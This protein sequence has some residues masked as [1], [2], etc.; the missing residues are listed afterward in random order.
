MKFEGL[1]LALRWLALAVFAS[2]SPTGIASA[3]TFTTLKSFGTLTNMTGTLPQSQLV[4]GPDGTLYG[5]ASQGPGIL[6]GTVF[7]LEPNGSNFT[8]LKWFTNSLDGAA[9]LGRLILLGN[10][11]Y[12]TT[13]ATVGSYAGAIFRLNTDGTGYAVLRHFADED[14]VVPTGGL[15][16]SGNTLY[17]IA[18]GFSGQQ[19][20]KINPDG[21]AFAVLYNFTNSPNPS[22]EESGGVL[23]GTTYGGGSADAG[24]IFKVNTDGTGFMELKHFS[25]SALDPNTGLRT[26]SDGANPRAGLTLNGGLLYGTA[27]RGGDHGFGTVFTLNTDGTGFT[28][29]KHF[30]GGDG[31]FPAGDV[32]LADGVLY[33][34]TSRGGSSDDGTVFRL[35]SNGTGYTV[36]KHFVWELGSNNHEGAQ[37]S[38]GLV[39]SG[40]ALYGV[41]VAGGKTSE[42]TLFKLNTDGTA[43]S[44]LKHFTSFSDGQNPAGG[45]TLSGSV[46]YGTAQLGGTGGAGIVFKM[47]LDGSGYEI[48]KH[49]TGS[50]GALPRG[51]LT[52]SSNELYGTTLSGGDQ[53]YGTVFKLNPD[54]TGFTVL[55]SFKGTVESDG[56]SP[57]AGLVL[58][59]STLYGAT[60]SGG[61]SNSGTVFTL[62]TD[63]TDYQVLRNF[64]ESPADGLNPVGDLT[65]SQGVLYGTTYRGGE[66]GYGTVFKLNADGTGYTVLRSFRGA[67]EGDGEYPSAGLVLS[68]N[69]LYGTTRSGG[70]SD[71]G[72]VFKLHTNGT[73]YAILR[74][75]S[76]YPDD[77]EG[78]QTR[79]T[80]SG[81]V[82]YGRTSAG[83]SSGC[84]TMFKMNTD[85]TGLVM[86]YHFTFC[87]SGQSELVWSDGTLYGTTLEGG[88][89]NIG[90]V[91]SL[92]PSKVLFAHP[93]GNSLVLD[94]LNPALGLQAAPYATGTYT[95]IAGAT[96]PYTNT[97]AG[98]QQFFRLIGN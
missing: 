79:L 82:L 20:F 8:V 23:Y 98:P 83:G 5:T 18:S 39:V 52:V 92:D 40:G 87:N 88:D 2:G 74:K 17:G 44:T 59:G 48:L 7:R 65:L 10:T 36:L 75:F 67:G 29:L 25:A 73:D 9:P 38:A 57:S 55:R 60:S 78:P 22:L 96:S 86:L 76:G 11:L 85:G 30:N 27:N 62:N 97:M 16:L 13:V 77:G 90:T 15:T 1:S 63:G 35:N 93:L 72:T 34:T 26:N 32:S 94:W 31:I 37:P 54:G 95:N 3:Q 24:T 80:L 49:F 84:G 46:F 28:V 71:H 4:P 41:T 21:T 81:N 6:K 89:W 43:F 68:G 14:G 33:G 61:T 53:D 64:P 70:A 47:H 51:G 19:L 42:G 58:S 69:T 56:E 91:F 66:R 45:L 12:G 50:D